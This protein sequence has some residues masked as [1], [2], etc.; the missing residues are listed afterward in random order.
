MLF[1]STT[2]LFVFLPIVLA[3]F[4]LIAR[5]SQPF[6]ALWLVLASV[7]FYGWWNAAFVPLLLVS[8][9]VNFPL[10]VRLAQ[11]AA[12]G[13]RHQGI[14]LAVGISFNLLLLAYFKY[15]NFLASAAGSLLGA[16]LG[17]YDI[18]L[19]IG[20]SFFTFTQIAFLVDA[21]RGAAREYK[22]VHYGLFVSYFPHLVAG[23]ILHHRE[24]M[25]QFADPS[26]YRP[27]WENFAVGVSI[28]S[29]GLFKKVVIADALAPHAEVVF[30]AA[31]AGKTVTVLEAW[32]GA[33]S[34]TFQLYF[35]FSGY[36][37]MAIGIS[38]LFGVRLPVNF[39]SP[40]K[41]KNIADFW[42][43]WHM[44]LSRFLRD[45]LYVPLG[46]SRRGPA[47]TYVNLLITMLLGGLWHGAGWTFVIWGA[48]HGIFL[49][50]HRALADSRAVRW[51]GAQGKVGHAIGVLLTFL[52][53]VVAWVFFRAESFQAAVAVL[54]GMAGMDGFAAVV[55]KRHFLTLAAL[56]AAVWILPNT[57]QIMA[58]YDPAIAVYRDIAAPRSPALAWFPSWRWLTVSVVMG[59]LAFVR[60]FSGQ[61]SPFLYFNF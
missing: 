26:T 58:K 30:A 49:V 8:V 10:G 33:L 34:Y 35:D 44:T 54:R 1:N 57:Q 14:L 61:E 6:A 32:S 28:L 24:M 37:V 56:A 7:T 31:A 19:P 60:L 12:A 17:P 16:Q 47:R 48:L 18:T 9:L 11:G 13:W 38:R 15:T 2:F 23:P 5:F 59:W 45:Y 22:L 4:F 3:G 51:I 39:D 40:Y 29:I 25:P 36:S 42:R 55:S 20:I 43:R 41:A 21:S 27:R 53:V 46:G 52:C 50:L